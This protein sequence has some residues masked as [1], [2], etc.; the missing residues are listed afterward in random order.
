MVGIVVATHGPL[1]E[2][3]VASGE[4]VMGKGDNVKPLGLYHGD[5]VEE[6][7]EK[8]MDAVMK[9]DKGDGVLILTDLLGGSPYNVSA[10]VLRALKNKVE[11]DCFYGVNLP[12]YLEVMGSR[13]FMN[14]SELKEHVKS[15]AATTY[16]MVTEKIAI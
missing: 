11:A 13:S 16:G 7:E 14:L 3:L 10:K 9:A 4:L 6:F 1:A 8:I 2:A 5:S 12:I 15:I